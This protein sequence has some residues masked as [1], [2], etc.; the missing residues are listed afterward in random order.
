MVHICHKCGAFSVLV[1]FYFTRCSMA[2]EPCS[3]DNF[4]VTLTDHGVCY[5][6]NRHDENGNVLDVTNSGNK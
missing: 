1:Y 5:T 6:F 3:A 4:S 2:D